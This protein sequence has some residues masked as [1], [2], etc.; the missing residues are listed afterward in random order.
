MKVKK[1]LYPIKKKPK[2]NPQSYAPDKYCRIVVVTV[3]AVNTVDRF[4]IFISSMSR[5]LGIIL[6]NIW[7]SSGCKRCAHKIL[8]AI[9]FAAQ[10][11]LFKLFCYQRWF[12]LLFS[13]GQSGTDDATTTT[14]TTK[15]KDELNC[16]SSIWNDFIIMEHK[17]FDTIDNNLPLHQIRTTKTFQNK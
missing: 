13:S 10:T 11:Q 1:N 9:S 15:W 17:R 14:T 4:T 12:L 7:I 2:K 5:Y 6:S 3:D 8:C 16:V